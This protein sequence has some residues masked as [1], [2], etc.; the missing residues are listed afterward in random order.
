MNDEAGFRSI[1]SEVAEYHGVTE[2]QILATM[3]AEIEKEVE[4]RKVKWEL[5]HRT[6]ARA[7]RPDSR[8]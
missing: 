5:E 3:V 4:A 8:G 7:D 1:V 6:A 2:D